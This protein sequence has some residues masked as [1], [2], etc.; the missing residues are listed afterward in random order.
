[1]GPRRRSE[2]AAALSQGCGHAAARRGVARLPACLAA[3]DPR[4]CSGGRTSIDMHCH[5]IHPSMQRH[6]WVPSSSLSV[7]CLH[8]LRLCVCSHARDVRS[9]PVH[10]IA[11]G[12]LRSVKQEALQLVWVPLCVVYVSSVAAK[13]TFM[14]QQARMAKCCFH[15]LRFPPLLPAP[16]SYY[17]GIPALSSG[18]GACGAGELTKPL[19]VQRHGGGTGMLRSPAVAQCGTCVCRDVCT[20]RT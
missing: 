7:R 6:A 11:A 16:V 14:L 15:S 19:R 12:R 8:M 18:P 13:A 5:G 4:A 3:A 2:R 1:M 17:S 10:A 20:R 9:V